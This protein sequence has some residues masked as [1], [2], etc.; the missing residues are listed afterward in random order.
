MQQRGLRHLLYREVVNRH[1]E[2][3]LALADM[4]RV[5]ALSPLVQTERIAELFPE[6]ITSIEP[7]R[8]TE[9]EALEV[10]DVDDDFEGETIFDMDP[11]EAIRILREMGTSVTI[12]DLSQE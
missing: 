4:V 2:R 12:E 7:T 9:A 1:A 11:E 6:F 5:A 8:L 3:E 10:A